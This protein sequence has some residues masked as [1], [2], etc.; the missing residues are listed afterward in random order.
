[1]IPTDEGAIWI[2][3]GTP[4]AQRMSD[5]TDDSIRRIVLAI[6]VEYIS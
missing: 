5:S 3:L 6:E 2:K 1:M 4:W